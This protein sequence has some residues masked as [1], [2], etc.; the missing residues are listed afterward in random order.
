L[1][2]FEEDRLIIR[3]VIDKIISENND[4]SYSSWKKYY[5]DYS[6][7]ISY[8]KDHCKYKNIRMEYVW[9]SWYLNTFVK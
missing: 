1:E 5:N 2:S 3:K 4:I 7:E 8:L 6:D 9:Y